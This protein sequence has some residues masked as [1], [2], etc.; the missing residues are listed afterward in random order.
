MA[1]EVVSTASSQMG[2]IPGALLESV[3]RGP[4]DRRRV[5]LTFSSAETQRLVE[6]KGFYLRDMHIRPSD[7]AVSGY[8]PHPPYFVDCNTLISILSRFGTVKDGCG[9]FAEAQVWR[10]LNDGTVFG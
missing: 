3:L 4:K 9:T 7:G 5:Y 1:E 10:L 8:M 6:Q 2:L